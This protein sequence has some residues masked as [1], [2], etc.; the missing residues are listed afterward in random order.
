MYRRVTHFPMIVVVLLGTLLL[1][2]P[3]AAAYQDTSL[4]IMR[5]NWGIPDQLDPQLSQ[6]GTWGVNGLDFEGLTRVDEEQHIVPAAAESWAFSDDKLT[7]TFHL[8]D[9]LVFSDG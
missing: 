7:L 3:P 9:G 4:K 2:F 5:V 6:E 1:G 8:R